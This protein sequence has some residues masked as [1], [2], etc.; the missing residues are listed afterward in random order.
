MVGFYVV[1]CTE[2]LRDGIE[3]YSK[4]VKGRAAAVDL[5]NKWA[6]L[7]ARN[8]EFHIFE[9]GS[10]VKIIGEELEVPQ[11]PTRQLIFRVAD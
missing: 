1:C 11:P 9:L 6:G 2:R 3:E 10:E 4:V 7:G 8:L 5:I